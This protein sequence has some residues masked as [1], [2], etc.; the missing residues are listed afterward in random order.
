M[1]Y[2]MKPVSAT[3][4][5]AVAC[6]QREIYTRPGVFRLGC[7]VM[8]IT[9]QS[10]RRMPLRVYYRITA[11]KLNIVLDELNFYDL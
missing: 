5:P 4:A 7:N 3:Y 2:R 6:I 8:D 10:A 11:F 1:K 9:K